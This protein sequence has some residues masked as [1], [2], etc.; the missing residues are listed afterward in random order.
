MEEEAVVQV[1]EA[2]DEPFLVVGEAEVQGAE[3]VDEAFLVV[4]VEEDSRTIFFV[5][6][7]N[8]IIGSV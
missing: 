7:F 8:T 2:V 4:G 5:I 6:W 3:V 1:A